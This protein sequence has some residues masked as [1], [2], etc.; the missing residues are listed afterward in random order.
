MSF[1]LGV[2]RFSAAAPAFFAPGTGSAAMLPG[3]EGKA[4]PGQAC[5]ASPQ[6]ACQPGVGAPT[7]AEWAEKWANWA[8]NESIIRIIQR[9]GRPVWGLRVGVSCMVYGV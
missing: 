7:R 8:L 5:W 9:V 4:V 3:P 2:W 6:D 1:T